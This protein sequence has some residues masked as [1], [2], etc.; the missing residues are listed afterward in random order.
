MYDDN[1][2]VHQ[3]MKKI[4]SLVCVIRYLINNNCRGNGDIIIESFI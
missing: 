3:S 2:P 4:A 1:K